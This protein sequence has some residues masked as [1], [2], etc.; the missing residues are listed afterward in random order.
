MKRSKNVEVTE[1]QPVEEVL[2]DTETDMKNPLVNPLIV[3]TLFEIMPFNLNEFKNFRLVSKLWWEITLPTIRKNVVLCLTD[4]KPEGSSSEDNRSPIESYIDW[5]NLSNDPYQ[6]LDRKRIQ[7]YNIRDSIFHVEEISPTTS[8]SRPDSSFWRQ[9][10]WTMTNLKLSQANFNS[11]EQFFHVV[12]QLTPNLTHLSLEGLS[13]KLSN[14]AYLVPPCWNDSFRQPAS[15]I[16]KNL[17]NIDIT[18]PLEFE[19]WIGRRGSAFCWVDFLSHF[20]NLKPYAPRWKPLWSSSRNVGLPRRVAGPLRKPI[21]PTDNVPPQDYTSRVL[22]EVAR[23]LDSDPIGRIVGGRNANPG[24]FPHHLQITI[25]K[26]YSN[27][28]SR[29]PAACGGTL[30][31]LFN[32]QFAVTAAHCVWRGS[33]GRFSTWP[34]AKIRVIAGDYNINLTERTEQ[35]RMPDKIVFHDRYDM[36]QHHPHNDI[37]LIFFKR[38]FTLNNFV[39]TLNLPGYAWELPSRGLLSG[40]GSITNIDN[41]VYPK[42]LKTAWLNTMP[43]K[44]CYKFGFRGNVIDWRQ[45]CMLGAN[46]GDG[47]CKGD[48]GGPVAARNFSQHGYGYSEWYLAGIVSFVI[49]ECGSSY[50]PTIFTR[51]SGHVDWIKTR[52]NEYIDEEGWPTGIP[53]EGAGRSLSLY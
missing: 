10:G 12:C 42:I 44:R 15:L 20:P 38:P 2:L 30:V 50:Y 31:E 7:N 5:L 46:N 9:V 13:F 4:R 14:K 48:S 36:D 34:K 27:I 22:D 17:K 39:A 16:N 53:A 23:Q 25:N 1:I 41:P 3:K 52:V 29:I 24:E 26:P 35:I 18:L 28:V 37:A 32:I 43:Q 33:P 45:F 40:W 19:Y 51:V 8:V 21:P 6:L 47:A 11:K 49:D